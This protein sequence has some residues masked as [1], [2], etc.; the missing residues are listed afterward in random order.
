MGHGFQLATGSTDCNM[1][2]SRPEGL[3]PSPPDENAPASFISMVFSGQLASI[4]ICQESRHISLRQE[5]SIDLSMPVQRGD[6]LRE[7]KCI[8]VKNFVKRLTATEC[9]GDR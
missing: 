8:T 4:L 6:F 2:M 9:T 3:L 7:R 1:P 5:D